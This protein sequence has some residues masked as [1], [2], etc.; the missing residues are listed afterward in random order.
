MGRENTTTKRTQSQ[1]LD[2]GNRQKIEMWVKRKCDTAYIAEQLGRSPKTIERELKR[3][4]VEQLGTLLNTY[5]TYSSDFAQLDYDEKAS[6]K[7]GGL[8]VGSDYAWV[9]Y[10]E[11]RILAGD[12]PYAALQ[13]AINDGLEFATHVSVQTLY[14]Y[15][16]SG[17][18][19]TRITNKDLLVKTKPAKSGYK[20][21]QRIKNPAAQSINERPEAANDRSELGNWELDHIC[22]AQGTPGGIFTMT[23]RKTRFELAMKVA[24]LTG[25]T[26]QERIDALERAIGTAAFQQ[27]F[28]SFTPDNG[29]SF[30]DFEK[31]EKSALTDVKR[32]TVYFAHCYC[33]WE[34]GSNENANRM[35]RRF[36]PKGTNFNNVTFEQI[37]TAQDWMNDYP[38]KK[39]GGRSAKMAVS[40]LSSE[41]RKLLETASSLRS[42]PLS[43]SFA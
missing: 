13:R 29:S 16:D 19:F 17:V 31:L 20:R 40:E 43:R 35:L 11:D 42:E 8:K 1:H 39:L 9:Q 28:K 3:G 4:Q 25:K 12:S 27:I 23:E 14:N 41:A 6:H 15:I 26:V 32:T 7:G 38:R 24:D 33:S 2:Y 22:G 36:F 34:R 30:L 37:Q 18:V 10:I 5:W 21:V